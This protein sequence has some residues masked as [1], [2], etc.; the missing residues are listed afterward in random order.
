V[1]VSAA[2]VE[3]ITESSTRKTIPF[4]LE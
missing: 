4:I 1:R 3:R 2:K